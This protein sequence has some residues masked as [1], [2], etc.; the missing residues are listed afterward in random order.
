LIDVIEDAPPDVAWRTAAQTQRLLELMSPVHR[1][2]IEAARAR[3]ERCVGA[4][5]R[6]TRRDPDGVKRQRAE[7][8]FD[9]LAGC[10]RTPGGG[11]SRQF[12]I[13]VEGETV[14]SRLLSGRECARLMGLSDDYVLPESFT[15]ACHLLGDGVAP[16]VVR[17]L[18][19]TLLRPLLGLDP[20]A[21]EA[22]A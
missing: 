22:A 17:H 6:R 9:G 1:R 18:S 21:T 7:V 20:P 5:Y 14:R 13:V 10:L 15:D 3:G 11:S 4:L 8:R 12:L 16:P 2:K 19:E